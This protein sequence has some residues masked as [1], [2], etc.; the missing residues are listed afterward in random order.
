M[1]TS[2]TCGFRCVQQYKQL[3]H[4]KELQSGRAHPRAHTIQTNTHKHLH[5]RTQRH[6]DR[7][8]GRRG[9]DGGG[10]GGGTSSNEDL[11][12]GKKVALDRDVKRCQSENGAL[13]DVCPVLLH[14]T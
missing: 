2:T 6:K 1:P 5:T 10:E 14:D 11:D 13:V 4:Q 12:A 7:E 8:R 9:V 3:L